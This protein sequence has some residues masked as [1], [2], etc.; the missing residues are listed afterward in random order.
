MAKR[1]IF[2]SS[3]HSSSEHPQEWTSQ[4]IEELH[5]GTRLDHFLLENLPGITRGEIRRLIERGAV[6]IQGTR[7]SKG[8]RLK[9]GDLVQVEI[10]ACNPTP[11]AQ[12]ELPLSV[13]HL[14]ADFLVLNKPAGWPCFPLFPGERNT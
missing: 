1:E 6:R 11:I 2:R 14:H 4:K 3:S 9:K 13:I 5:V 8:T 7:P 12:S 10:A